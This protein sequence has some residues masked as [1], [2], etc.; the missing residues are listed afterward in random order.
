MLPRK[1]TIKI[2]GE[3]MTLQLDP[4]KTLLW[5]IRDQLKL[6]G[7]KRGCDHGE[8]GLCTVLLD[9]LPVKSCLVLAV[10]ADGHE[11]TTV[12]GL[13]KDGTLSALQRA[14]IEHGALQCGF[15]TPAFLV[16]G[17]WLVEKDSH[18][19]RED[20]INAIDGVLCR[21]TGYRQIIDAMLD[22]A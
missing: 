17:T 14:M 5:V 18:P 15:C 16:V 4:N 7:T 6:K 2:N 13:S 22:S 11:I 3:K 19:T 10:E 1:T 21:C 12:E 20:V 8:C 9:G